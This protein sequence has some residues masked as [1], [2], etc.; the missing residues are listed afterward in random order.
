MLSLYW[1]LI[2]L[3]MAGDQIVCVCVCVCSLS[4]ITRVKNKNPHMFAKL[5]REHHSNQSKRNQQ[6]TLQGHGVERGVSEE[7]LG[8]PLLCVIAFV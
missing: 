2:M 3:A 1:I 7:M 4:L 5:T 8:P 6:N